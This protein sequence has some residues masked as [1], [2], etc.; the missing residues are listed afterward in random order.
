MLMQICIGKKRVKIQMIFALNRLNQTAQSA[1]SSVLRMW[2]TVSFAAII[3]SLAFTASSYRGENRNAISR[4]LVFGTGQNLLWFT[5]LCALVSTVL[6]RIVVVTAFSY[7]LSRYALEMVVRVLVLEL[8]PLTAA[9]FVALR[10]TLPDGIELSE[11][12]AKGDLELQRQQGTDPIQREA[13]P[14]VLAGMFLVPMLVAVS[15]ITSLV[16]AYVTIYGLTPWGFDGYTRVVGQ[17]FKPAISVILVLKTLFLSLAVSVI[18]MAS[19][20]DEGTD[21]SVQGRSKA[22]RELASMVRL[23]SVALLIELAS[24]MGNYY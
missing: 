18:P 8:I 15:C 22:A 20:L 2:R 24:L 17:V 16:I 19:A 14:R 1:F 4:Q 11:L 10:S 5:V 3:G 23:F 6:I 12:R 13:L 9:V 7:G 21:L